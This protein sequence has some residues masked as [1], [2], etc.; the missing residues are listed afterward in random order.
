MIINFSVRPVNVTGTKTITNPFGTKD[1]IDV[2]Y[3]YYSPYSWFELTIRNK[4][5]G[6]IILQDG[7]GNSYG[8]QYPAEL[9]RTVKVLNPGN[10]HIEMSGN[11]I[12]AK[13]DMHVKKE[14]NFNTT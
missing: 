10:L 13:V 2:K 5:T 6:Q 14:G 1:D 8:K 3:D 9:N 7:F 11:Q 4:N 12:T